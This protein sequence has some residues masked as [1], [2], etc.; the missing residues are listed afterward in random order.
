MHLLSILTRIFDGEAP[1]LQSFIDHHKKIGIN[2]F[3]FLTQPRK[4]EICKKI[5]AKN[6]I[7]TM[8]YL[9]QNM[10]CHSQKSKV[11]ILL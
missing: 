4:S 8:I 10:K 2:K 6:N 11:N 5:L 3:Y 9:A 7:D 1:Y